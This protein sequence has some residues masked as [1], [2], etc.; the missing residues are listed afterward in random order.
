MTFVTEQVKPSSWKIILVE[1][2]IPFES[3]FL[4]NYEAG[5][6]FREMSRLIA[7][8][9]SFTLFGTYAS[10]NPTNQIYQIESARVGNIPYQKVTSLANLRITNKSFYYD[11]ATTNIY[12]HFDNFSRP[13]LLGEISI[14]VV[15]GYASTTKS[16][17]TSYYNDIYY[18][19]RV[20]SIPSLSKRKDPTFFGK[21]QFQGGSIKLDNIDGALDILKDQDIFG[22]AVRVKF[23]YDG[24][25][26]SEFRQI[27]Q[28]F[29][30]DISWGRS[31]FDLKITDI[32][33]N[34]ETPIPKNLFNTTD[35]PDLDADDKSKP[36]PI[37]YGVIRGGKAIFVEE[38][39]ASSKFK[40]KYMDTEFYSATALTQVYVD[41]VGVSADSSDLTTGTFI[42]DT[43]VW[44][45]D[46]EVTVDFTGANVTDGFDILKDILD[47]YANMPFIAD[48]FNTTEWTAEETNS[49]TQGVY[50]GDRKK[51][52]EI[53][54]E[55]SVSDDALFFVQD[56]GKLT[57]RIFDSNRTPVKTLESYDWANEPSF[58]QPSSEFL[59]SVR[60]KY[61]K[62]HSSG[63]FKSITDVTAEDEAFA[64][65]KKLKERDIETTLVNE[66]DAIA[67]G[68]VIMDRSK[69]V[70]DTVTRKLYFNHVDLEIMDF[71]IADHSRE[72]ET[73][74]WAEYEI[75][76]ISKQALKGE[77]SL[78]MK[79]IRDFTP[80]EGNQYQQG[81]IFI[82][83][84]YGYTVP[85][86][87]I[88]L[89][90]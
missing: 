81:N 17:G 60:I 76:G 29:I 40:F 58:S 42:L 10:D 39:V 18:D 82:Q 54:E 38:T 9:S 11:I 26:Y 65:Y 1:L 27:F 46:G 7:R 56:D 77:M 74:D 78:T 6:W 51:I 63:R 84:V 85:G 28:G 24:I 64:R 8:T 19:P 14:G 12:F 59:S 45:G 50:I 15:T 66:A 73:E 80:S 67:K 89:G 32:R 69:K 34:L 43:S 71:I 36:I 83:H 16:D 21:L 68:G 55:I 44:S 3:A 49:R 23:G 86:V 47:K 30:D 70:E 79:R 52:F 4:I 20:K 48:L 41:G 57:A 2:D 31:E 22:Q 90:D 37:A 72:T 5:I 13:G 88:N 61:S 25:A 87:T 75:T 62:N 33:K 53:I 35:Y